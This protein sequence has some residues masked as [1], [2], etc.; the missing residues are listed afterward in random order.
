MHIKSLHGIFHRQGQSV[1]VTQ[2]KLIMSLMTDG[3]SEIQCPARP[4]KA[5][6]VVGC[7]SYLNAKP[8]TDG[9]GDLADLIVKFSPA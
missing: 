5:G 3:Y 6:Q 1:K 4:K 8:L 7:V 2:K 9:L